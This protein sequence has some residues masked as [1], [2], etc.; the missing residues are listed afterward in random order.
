MS[1]SDTL[2]DSVALVTGAS[3]GIGEATAR[4]LASRGADVTISARRTGR[5][6]ALRDEL[7]DDYDVDVLVH[8]AD[9]TDA[10]AVEDLVSD[11][12]DTLGGLDIVVNN[13]GLGRDETTIEDLDLDA[14]HQMMAVNCDGMFYVARAAMPHLKESKGNLIFLGSMSGQ[15]PRPASPVYAATK[16]WTRGLALSVQAN[17]GTEGVGVTA[18]NPTEV[19]TEFGS[20]DG[21]A[22]SEQLDPGE[23]ASPA[24]VADAIAFAAEQEDPNVVQELDLFRRDKFADW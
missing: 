11:A 9:V 2:S 19:R 15:Y 18:V 6:E 14:Y 8:P 12:V 21:A 17:A 4:E 7:T 13:A 5:L 16:W 20:E 22:F 23:A 24:D 10:D 1:D 3:S